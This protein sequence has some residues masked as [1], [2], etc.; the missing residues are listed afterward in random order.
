MILNCPRDTSD[1]L[2]QFRRH[3]NGAEALKG[4]DQRMGKALQAVSVLDD[5]FALDIVEHFAHLLGREFMMIEERNEARDGALE[6]DVVLPERVVGI[7]EECLWRQ[8][9]SSW[10]LASS[11]KVVF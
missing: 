4:I 10:L 1:F 3:G 9:S 2:V 8:A 5:A 11:K 7:N 6:V